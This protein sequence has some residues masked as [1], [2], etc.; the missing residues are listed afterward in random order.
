MWCT[1]LRHDGSTSHN[2]CSTRGAARP[3]RVD[4]KTE[5]VQRCNSLPWGQGS[6]FFGY[7]CQI[8][9]RKPLLKATAK[10]KKVSIRGLPKVYAW[11]E[12]SN[13]QPK[14]NRLKGS[15]CTGRTHERVWGYAYP[16]GNHTNSSTFRE[17][18]NRSPEISQKVWV[19][20]AFAG[21][22]KQS[23]RSHFGSSPNKLLRVGVTKGCTL[24]WERRQP[25][26]RLRSLLF[27]CMGTNHKAG[28]T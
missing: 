5:N 13:I 8:S 19:L 4:C 28:R 25:P 12:L 9:L 3:G 24:L 21:A 11:C 2:G 6:W 26:R 27:Q 7:L 16:S 14:L 18:Q 22:E 20:S 15:E 10:Q 23:N 17:K 1:A